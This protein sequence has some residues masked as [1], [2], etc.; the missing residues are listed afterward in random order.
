ME[1]SIETQIRAETG[2]LMEIDMGL[3]EKN[4]EYEQPASKVRP[5]GLVG[6]AMTP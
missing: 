1:H 5:V 4:T 6:L 3:R 2:D